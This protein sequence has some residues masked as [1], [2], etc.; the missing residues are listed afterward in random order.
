MAR[1]AKSKKHSRSGEYYASSGKKSEESQYFCCALFIFVCVAFGNLLLQLSRVEQADDSDLYEYFGTTEAKF[2][3][4]HLDKKLTDAD[5]YPYLSKIA[6]DFERSRQQASHGDEFLAFDRKPERVKTRLS[7]KEEAQE[8][9]RLKSDL[10]KS[11]FTWVKEPPPNNKMQ[12]AINAPPSDALKKSLMKQTLVTGAVEEVM[13][14]QIEASSMLGDKNKGEVDNRGVPR[15]ISVVDS[16]VRVNVPDEYD[17]YAEE[18]DESDSSDSSSIH[19][20]KAAAASKSS[21]SSTP[22][23]SSLK[24]GSA[25]GS[26]SSKLKKSKAAASKQLLATEWA[27]ATSFSTSFRSRNKYGFYNTKSKALPTSVIIDKSLHSLGYRSASYSSSTGS[28]RTPLPLWLIFYGQK[29]PSLSASALSSRTHFFMCAGYVPKLGRTLPSWKSFESDGLARAYD[30]STDARVE[31]N[32]NDFVDKV[33]QELNPSTFLR[34]VYRVKSSTDLAKL[35]Q[36]S[37]SHIRQYVVWSEAP[38]S[39]FHSEHAPHLSMAVPSSKQASAS[40]S[41]LLAQIY[42]N[43]VLLWDKKKFIIRVHFSILSNKPLLAVSHAA[44]VI[45]SREAFTPFT[46]KKY[47]RAP[48]FLHCRRPKATTKQLRSCRIT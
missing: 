31:Q 13:Q 5:K 40:S 27:T 20:S 44:A 12:Q 3:T 26:S 48:T 1:Y 47:S 23:S 8:S 38:E 45:V 46:G 2:E 37:S 9:A 21:S 43:G 4:F 35:K 29:C 33:M 17:D 6:I 14:G 30:A 25:K 22:S 10:K 32:K 11:L 28:L 16:S 34:R 15:Y 18:A 42:N 36:D 24:T 19:D 41:D 7:K 39:A